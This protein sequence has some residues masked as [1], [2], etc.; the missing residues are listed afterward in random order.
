M[1]I[2][3]TPSRGSDQGPRRASEDDGE[4][5]QNRWR[6][7][8]D[9]AD[10]GVLVLRGLRHHFEYANERYAALVG[11][12]VDTLLGRPFAEA[13]PQVAAHGLVDIFDQVRSTGTA[14]GVRDFRTYRDVH[15]DGRMLERWFD[16]TVQ[17]LRE[18]GQDEVTGLLVVLAEVTEKV[19]A[20]HAIE[21]LATERAALLEDIERERATTEALFRITAAVNRAASLDEVSQLATEALCERLA[22]SR[23]AVLLYAPD[24][25]MRFHSWRGLSEG[26][27]AAVEGHSPW[28]R[29]TR[30]PQAIAVP[31]VARCAELASYGS[32][33]EREGI[34]ALLFVPLVHDGEL[35]G[36]FMVYSAEPRS[37]AAHELQVS[38]AI[39]DQVAAAVRGKRD[40][41]ERG[42]MI[43]ELRDNLRSN[44]LLAAILGHDLRNP[45]A[46]ILTA[47]ELIG[48]KSG[49]EGI[50]RASERIVFS[51]QRMNRMIGQLLDY[52]RARQGLAI[53]VDPRPIDLGEV[54]RQ[55]VDEL[56]AAWPGR[57][58][59]LEVMG[60]T[61]GTWDADRM[62][63]VAS[64]LL[65]NAFEH[66]GVGGA[67]QVRVDGRSEHDVKVAVSNK[68]AIAP[69]LLA[70]VFLPFR[71]NR[72]GHAQGRGLGLG[73]YITRE[74]VRAHGGEIGVRSSPHE[75]TT[76]ELTIPRGARS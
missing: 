19:R 40:L 58:V 17:P 49:D 10:I 32:L 31:D 23:A 48:R 43:E 44:E 9:A 21:Q 67:V 35:L 69:D 39:A 5:H 75:G 42:R 65:G 64:N 72:P 50:T 3:F 56:Q 33:F 14:H 20:R 37:F 38:R 66:G 6:A 55:V 30:D 73:L 13:L 76:F 63:Q 34:R 18:D 51:S 29:E 46:S 7:L 25:V 24:G 41:E 26:Y 12:D 60:E 22:V 1:A 11:R 53:P 52:T 59:A 36:K 27:R 68:G 57:S 74:I 16:F 45:L 28:S 15:G 62:A 70:E 54:L 2:A 61:R 47:A 8:L 71:S 4:P